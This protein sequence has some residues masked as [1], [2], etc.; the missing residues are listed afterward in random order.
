MLF[1]FHHIFFVTYTLFQ[2]VTH[3]L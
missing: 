1:R 2:I 3:F